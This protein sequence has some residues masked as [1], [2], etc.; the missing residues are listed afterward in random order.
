M[1]RFA[2]MSDIHIGAFRQPELRE[3]VSA[4]FDRAIDRCIESGVDFVVMS[5]DVFDSNIPDLS[6]V[7]R[8]TGK[9]REARDKGVRFYVVY[10]SHDYSPN[11][12]SVVDVL[13]SAGLFTKVE[14]PRQEGG[15]LEL[16]FVVDETGAK[17]CGISGKKLSLDRADYE[18]LDREKLESEPGF[19]VFVFHGAIEELKPPSLAAMDAMPASYLPSGFGYYAG[20]HVHSRMTRGLPGRRN[21]AYPGPLFATDFRDLEPLSRGEAHGFYIVDFQDEVTRTEFARTDVCE[22][23]GL[24]Y[25]A[26]GKEALQAKRELMELARAAEV[27]DKVVLL[28]V[29]GE[30]AEGT[31]ADVGIPSIRKELASRGPLCVLANVTQLTSRTLAAASLSPRAPQETERECFIRAIASV[32]S[33]EPA[34]TGESGVRLSLELLK[35]LKEEKNESE[36]KADYQSRTERA[37]LGVLGLEA[38]GT[39]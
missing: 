11:H 35:T 26:Q 8:A 24:E 15:R 38:S 36:T 14:R 17:L 3:L 34:L 5:G 37:G 6:S 28:R 33:P 13:E 39:C 18:S 9:I 2:H 10:G 1:P 29:D 23:L 30:L 32:K 7:R 4:A 27:R 20:G 21:I 19:K 25:S 31:T 16:E 12:V 22:V